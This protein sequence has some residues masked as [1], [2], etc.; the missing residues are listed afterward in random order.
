[1][2]ESAYQ[3]QWC[4]EKGRVPLKSAP[5][6]SVCVLWDSADAA[7]GFHGAK[8]NFALSCQILVLYVVISNFTTI[9][10]GKVLGK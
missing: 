2:I 3:G 5:D 7:N 8:E 10:H 1:M 4:E 9:V 6:L